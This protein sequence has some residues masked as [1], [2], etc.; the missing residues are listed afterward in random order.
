VACQLTPPHGGIDGDDYSNECPLLAGRA[1]T[2]ALTSGFGTGS[3]FRVRVVSATHGRGAASTAQGEVSL[4][5]REEKL[6]C[7]INCLQRCFVE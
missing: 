6:G 2:V 4:G 3:A 1:A 5:A 7:T